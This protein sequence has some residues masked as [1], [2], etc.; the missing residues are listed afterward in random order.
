[1]S[2]EAKVSAEINGEINSEITGGVSKRP[3][4]RKVVA[5]SCYVACIIFIVIFI[6][7]K[8]NNSTNEITGTRSTTGITFGDY[9]PTIVVSGSMEP[10]MMTNSIS[11]CKKANI[12]DIEVGDIVA[13][14][15]N[16]EMVTHRVIEKYTDEN[17]EWYLRTKGDNNEFVDQVYVRDS[18][19]RGKVVKTWNNTANVI[20][21]YLI[22]PGE[23][24]SL[25]IGQ[26]I[27]WMF[28]TVAIF[29]VTIHWLWGFI[30]MLLKVSM[31]DEAYEK[32][33]KQLE[34]DIQSMIENK[35]YLRYLVDTSTET[36]KAKI[37]NK[38]ARAR[39][40]REIRANTES[41]KDFN[42]AIKTSKWLEKQGKK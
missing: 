11:L 15:F 28:I 30:G 40:M 22:S 17:E 3:S 25:A 38:L 24:D 10:I 35:E 20:N 18:M 41:V 14:T 36:G 37:H 32:E 6:V 27:I 7:N 33:L 1:M 34:S 2:R 23:I 13:F 16:N 5:I 29:A 4:G 8:L 12:S 26:T 39:M 9:F 31:K 19:V 42:K 21:K